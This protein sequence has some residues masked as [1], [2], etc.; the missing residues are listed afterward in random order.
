MTP[1]RGGI[2]ANLLASL[3][4]APV[5]VMPM[6]KLPPPA[7]PIL[8]EG[9]TVLPTA[10]AKAAAKAHGPVEDLPICVICQMPLRASEDKESIWCTHTFHRP[11]LVQW[12]VLANKGLQDC[13]F[14]C[15]YSPSDVPL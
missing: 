8:P 2:P 4:E 1:M 10:A 7:R 15:V 12:R 6:P 9:G 13:P 3:P 11:C 5:A 14:R